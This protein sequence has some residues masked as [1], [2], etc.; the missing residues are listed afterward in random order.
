MGVGPA[1]SLLGGV[2]LALVP[3]PVLFYYYGAR[4]REKSK[5]APTL[6]DLVQYCLWD[7][8]A[9][10]LTNLC[11]DFRPRTKT[12]MIKKVARRIWRMV[13]MGRQGRRELARRRSK[14]AALPKLVM[15]KKSRHVERS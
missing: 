6:V 14:S 9:M 4:L 5:F 3:M 11:L 13:S 10:I 7:V 1:G 8:K 12:A 15:E 2:A